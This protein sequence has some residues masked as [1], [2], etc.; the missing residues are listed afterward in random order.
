MK[1]SNFSLSKMIFFRL[2]SAGLSMISFRFLQ[3]CILISF[4]KEESKVIIKIL[5]ETKDPWKRNYNG[6]IQILRD[7]FWPILD[8]LPPNM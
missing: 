2:I 5:I 8:P 3:S 6:A 1:C 7:T 4:R